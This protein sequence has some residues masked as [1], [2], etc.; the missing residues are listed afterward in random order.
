MSKEIQFYKE[1]FIE[2]EQT[3]MIERRVRESIC[4]SLLERKKKLELEQ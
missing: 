3:R 4:E 1:S 2:E